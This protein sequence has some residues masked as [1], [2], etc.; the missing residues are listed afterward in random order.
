[1]HAFNNNIQKAK[2]DGSLSSRPACST[3]KFQDNQGYTKKPGLKNSLVMKIA[4]WG[5]FL[6]WWT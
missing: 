5:T 2:V 4:V 6:A 1:M 3:G